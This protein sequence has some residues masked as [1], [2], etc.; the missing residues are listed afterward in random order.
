M[1]VKLQNGQESLDVSRSNLA[2]LRGML[3]A[4]IGQCG[5]VRWYAGCENSAVAGP[6]PARDVRSAR[7]SPWTDVPFLP[8][9]LT[10]LTY[11][12]Y[13]KLNSCRFRTVAARRQADNELVVWRA[14]PEF[15]GGPP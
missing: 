5:R 6:G 10:Y 11:P 7:S 1:S 2:F 15:A 13:P 9:Y 4:S 8:D 14:G 12:S 3:L